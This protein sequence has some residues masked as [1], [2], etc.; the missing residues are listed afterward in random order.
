MNTLFA[1]A[2]GAAL[3]GAVFGL[4]ALIARA[5]PA[6]VEPLESAR[7]REAAAQGLSGHWKD[8]NP[9]TRARA[10]GL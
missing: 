4:A 6:S 5:F 9:E 8:D 1:V 3:G 2:F 10:A 7:G